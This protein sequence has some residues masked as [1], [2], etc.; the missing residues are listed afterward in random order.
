MPSP[1]M[2]AAAGPR[3]ALQRV[4][5][6]ALLGA[7]LVGTLAVATQAHLATVAPSDVPKPPEV[8]AERA[9]KILAN[10]GAGDVGV[11][12]AFW[13]TVDGAGALS[14]RLDRRR[15]PRPR[16]RDESQVRLS[17]EPALSRPAKPLPLRDRRRPT[18]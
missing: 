18:L 6:W 15:I 17:S 10:V 11:D 5:A 7:I 16:R 1:E 2:V 9:R 3:G 8:L 4:Q 13:F 14:K 12:S